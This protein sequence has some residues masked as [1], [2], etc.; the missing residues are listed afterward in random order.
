M[1]RVLFQWMPDDVT[2]VELPYPI[3]KLHWGSN[4]R[5]RVHVIQFLAL[6][7]GQDRVHM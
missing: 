3:S 2:R 1:V 7:V 5:H 4:C 6:A